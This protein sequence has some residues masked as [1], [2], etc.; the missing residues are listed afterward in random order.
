MEKDNME[1]SYGVLRKFIHDEINK[2]SISTRAFSELMGISHTTMNRVLNEQPDKQ[3]EPTL[4]FLV[5]LATV[6]KIDLVTL[7]SITYPDLIKLSPSGDARVFAEGYEQ[8]P[9]HIKEAIRA[10]LVTHGK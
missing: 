1:R 3:Q 2:R 10:L 5:K 9:D 6:T 8:A 7:M 4:D